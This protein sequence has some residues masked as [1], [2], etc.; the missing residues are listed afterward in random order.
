MSWL[1]KVPSSVNA[2]R[3]F[4]Q[5]TKYAKYRNE[6][7]YTLR[8]SLCLKIQIIDSNRLWGMY[9]IEREKMKE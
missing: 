9:E 4:L 5:S 1:L 8:L 7:V 3:F 6:R 2:A